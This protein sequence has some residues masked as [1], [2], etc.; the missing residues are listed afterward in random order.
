MNALQFSQFQKAQNS[1]QPVSRRSNAKT[2]SF[3][4]VKI[5]NAYLQNSQCQKR[6]FCCIATSS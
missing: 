5:H 6:Q 3:K 1:I 4:T 2:A